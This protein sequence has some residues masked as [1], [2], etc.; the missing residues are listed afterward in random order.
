MKKS[1]MIGAR[2]SHV[3]E[4]DRQRLLDL[5]QSTL[6]VQFAVVSALKNGRLSERRLVADLRSV[7]QSIETLI[8]AGVIRQ[9]D[10]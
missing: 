5:Q 4:L 7:L 2:G 1:S 8:E 3:T 9:S 6:R 10:L